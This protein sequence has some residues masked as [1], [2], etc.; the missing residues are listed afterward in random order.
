MTT[1]D[2]TTPPAAESDQLPKHTTPTWEVELLIS[3]VAVFAMLQLPGWLDDRYF[4]L[5]PRF[6][7]DWAVM[8]MMTYLYLKSA[9][10][11]LAITFALHLSLRARWIAKVGM[12]SVYPEGVRWEKHRVGPIQMEMEKNRDGNA[13]LSIERAD[14]QAT[15]IFAL[16]VALAASLLMLTMLVVCGFILSLAFTWLSGRHT[17]AGPLFLICM[18][19]VIAPLVLLKS[20]DRLYGARLSQ[21]GAPRRWLAKTLNFYDR[22][23]FG[24]RSGV[25]ALLASH[26]NSRFQQLFLFLIFGGLTAAVMFQLNTLQSPQRLGSYQLFPKAVNGA[27]DIRGAHYDDQRDAVH[28]PAVPYVPSLVVAGPYLQLM[29]PFQPTED[30]PALQKLCPAAVVAGE[31]A[32]RTA[33]TL[34]CLA[35][36]HPVTLDGVPMAA[37]HYDVASDPRTQRPA[38]QAMIDVR[39]LASG[40]HELRVTRAPIGEFRRDESDG[41]GEDVIPFWH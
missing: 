29:V 27:R 24:Q 40:R 11:I 21:H 39:A 35:R 23:G 18:M 36:I 28:D 4:A 7:A 30:T 12:H 17:P 31:V 6:N 8:L 3:G 14:N 25:M 16:G 20:F 33:S 32:A 1:I 38:L 13:L 9:A 15:I 22:V 41:G 10:V 2:P 34:D 37:L 5:F 19:V 26:A